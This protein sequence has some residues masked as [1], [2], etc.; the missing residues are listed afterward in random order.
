[1][2]YAFN[3]KLFTTLLFLKQRPNGEEASFKGQGPWQVLVVVF[4]IPSTWCLERFINSFSLL[5]FYFYF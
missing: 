4:I 2:S 3:H 1:M 5:V